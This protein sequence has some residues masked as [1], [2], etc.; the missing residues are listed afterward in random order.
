MNATRR[1]FLAAGM[2]AASTLALSRLRGASAS[3]APAEIARPAPQDPD[4]VFEFVRAGHGNLARVK[5][6]LAADPR[7][8]LAAWDWGAGDWETALGGASH[9]GNR[10]I[11][12]YLLEHGARQDLFCSAMLGER[13]A[14]LALVAAHPAL[15][16]TDG[17][18]GL[19]L[20]YHAAISGDVDLAQGIAPHLGRRARDCNQALIAA[21]R[22]GHAPM[23]TWLLANGV[24]NPQSK[25]ALGKTAAAYAEEKGFAD[26]TAALQSAGPGNRK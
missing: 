3:A 4:R 23:T 18:H 15:A 13:D 12:R 25:D 16:N 8:A 11:A 10:E 14:V 6:M 19:S 26:V 20:L 7:L 2:A 21:A 1:S 17:P 9:L 24:T 5:E 22:G